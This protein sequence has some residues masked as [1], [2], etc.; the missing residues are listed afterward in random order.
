MLFVAYQRRAGHKF[1]PELLV[2]LHLVDP[3][4]K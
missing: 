3:L 1:F 2:A 4:V